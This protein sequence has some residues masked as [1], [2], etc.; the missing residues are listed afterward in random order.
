MTGLLIKGDKNYDLE[1]TGKKL[2]AREEGSVRE[3]AMV[4]GGEGR[5]RR[6]RL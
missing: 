5:R 1:S 2:P 6:G 4:S 3:T